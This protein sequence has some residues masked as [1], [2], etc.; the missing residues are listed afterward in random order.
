M[1]PELETILSCQGDRGLNRGYVSFRY[2]DWKRTGAFLFE[3]LQPALDTVGVP[4]RYE[5]KV[6]ETMGVIEFSP[7]LTPQ[8]TAA[9]KSV[10][11][12][13]RPSEAMQ[14]AAPPVALA[15]PPPDPKSN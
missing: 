8:I 11:D 10:L 1:I 2:G 4:G 3:E 13:R 15:E 14:P 5:L 6:L 12:A 9:L 7:D